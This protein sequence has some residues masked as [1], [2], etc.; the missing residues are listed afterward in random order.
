M[1][2]T[3]E[4][5]VGTQLAVGHLVGIDVDSGAV[6]GLY[7]TALDLLGEGDVGLCTK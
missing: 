5:T 4:H 3:V 2:H 6:D 1:V 7:V